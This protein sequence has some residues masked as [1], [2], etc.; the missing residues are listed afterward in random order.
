MRCED[1]RELITGLVDNELSAEERGLLDEH[2]GDCLRCQD[3]H[4]LELM[5]KQ[6][7]R[8]ASEN[9]T[10]P[11]VLRE[12]ILAAGGKLPRGD[13][14]P[15]AAR[16]RGWMLT[17]G[18]RPAF[19]IALM[20]LFFFPLYY[21]LRPAKNIALETF[22]T[23][24]EV[25]AGEKYKSMAP[26]ADI[27][28]LKTELVAAVGGR[29]APMGF[30]LSMM[31]LYP[32]AGFVRNIN[33]RE[34][35]VTVYQGKGPGV[36]CITLLGTESDAPRSAQLFHDPVKNINFYSFSKNGLNGVLHKEGDVI[37]IMLS[38]MPAEDLLALVRA[39]ARQA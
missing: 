39:K 19:A 30:D 27:T 26:I 1:A 3:A 9:L 15:I 37:C 4:R 14:L 25:D 8:A 2:L 38:K 13:E 29:F 22:A 18:W 34:V 17:P 23:H 11:A 32:V 16:I 20:V 35:I 12:K 36:T 6:S 24:Q 21:W 7:V 5:L 28:P 10:A 33:N 31:Q